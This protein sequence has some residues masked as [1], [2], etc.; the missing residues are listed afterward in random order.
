MRYDY[1]SVKEAKSSRK[2]ILIGTK[3]FP[4]VSWND[5]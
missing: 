5:C 3:Y 2:K 1:T 4:E